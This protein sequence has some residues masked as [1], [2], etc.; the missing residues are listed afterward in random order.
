MQAFRSHVFAIH[1]RLM[2]EWKENNQIKEHIHEALLALF[3][4]N[5]RSFENA[6]SQ[7]EVWETRV[8]VRFVFGA[9]PC[10]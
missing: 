10:P 7:D 4:F 5:V 3:I 1:G 9:S 2:N 6:L 8:A